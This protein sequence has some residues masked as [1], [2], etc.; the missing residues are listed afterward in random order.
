[1]NFTREKPEA[2]IMDITPELAEEMLAT[3]TGN[4]KTRGWY[5]KLLSA[6]M[7]RG[8][9]RVTSQ[10]I[11]FNRNGELK[12][13]H[14]RLNACIDS[15]VSFP[16]VVV[17]G[18]REDIYQVID[19]GM[20]R[21]YGDR[22][23][24]AKPVAE[25]VRLGCQFALG[26]TVVTADQINP[27]LEAGFGKA[28]ESL[29]E[30]CGTSVKYYSIAPMKLAAVISIMNGSDASYVLQQYRA[31]CLADFDS[32]SRASQALVRQ[33][34]SGK[35]SGTKSREALTRGLKVFDKDRAFITKI[36]ITE[37]DIDAAVALVRSVL[38]NLL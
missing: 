13:A 11:G 6:A 24:I 16:S 29:L 37:S 33:V 3:S 19:T 17:L 7:K 5:V 4:R 15:G 26:S 2:M 12:D 38:N 9:W 22:L 18:L 27:F 34:V 36:Q 23:N 31:L 10:G 14:H 20:T 28:V 35:V 30:Y 8:E 1:M 32:M 21:S 25:V